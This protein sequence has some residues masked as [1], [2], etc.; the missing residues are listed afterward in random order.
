MKKSSGETSFAEKVYKVVKILS[1]GGY[2]FREEL[3]RKIITW[4]KQFL[5]T[6]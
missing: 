2:I 1:I 5:E 6:E 4:E 3:K